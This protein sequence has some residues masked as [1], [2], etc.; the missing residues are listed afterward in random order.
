MELE[1]IKMGGLELD[2]SLEKGQCRL[3]SSKEIELIENGK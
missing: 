1:R 3:L 2:Y